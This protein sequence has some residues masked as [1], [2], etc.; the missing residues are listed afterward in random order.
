MSA[1][2]SLRRA[3][4]AA[5]AQFGAAGC[6]G[7]LLA[8]QIWAVAHGVAMLAQSG[9][10]AGSAPGEEAK[11]ILETSVA[12]FIEKAVRDHSLKKVK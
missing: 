9:Y 11:S 5:L 7:R 8:A 6:D 4:E 10:F 1:L 12:A 3:T 2:E